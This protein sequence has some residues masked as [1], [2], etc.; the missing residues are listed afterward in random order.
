[1]PIFTPSNNFLS[2]ART[3]SGSV[4]DDAVN[5]RSSDGQVSENGGRDSRSS[6][7]PL[8][9][10]AAAV[11]ASTNDRWYGTPPTNNPH[12]TTGVSTQGSA[13]SLLNPPAAPAHTKQDFTLWFKDAKTEA[14]RKLKADCRGLYAS[15]TQ[16]APGIVETP[17]NQSKI[18]CTFTQEPNSRV[19]LPESVT[20]NGYP[21]TLHG[22]RQVYQT[23]VSKPQS[24]NPISDAKNNQSIIAQ[25]PDRTNE[26]LPIKGETGTD[27]AKLTPELQ[28]VLYSVLEQRKGL[29]QFVSRKSHRDGENQSEVPLLTQL[30]SKLKNGQ[31]RLNGQYAITEVNDVTYGKHKIPH[32]NGVGYRHVEIKI[33]DQE[34]LE[35]PIILRLSQVAPPFR[36]RLLQANELQTVHS[37]L[38]DQGMDL[39]QA[40]LF[41]Y[42]GVGRNA[43]LSVYDELVKAI[44]VGQIRSKEQLEQALKDLVQSGKQIRGAHFVQSPEQMSE[45]E[46]AACL[47]LNEKNN[48]QIQKIV[49]KI[50]NNLVTVPEKTPHESV[51]PTT[52][53]SDENSGLTPG[54]VRQRVSAIEQGLPSSAFTQLQGAL[55]ATTQNAMRGE[56]DKG[57]EA[58]D[59]WDSLS[60]SSDTL[61]SVDGEFN[62]DSKADG[63]QKHN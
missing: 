8:L 54:T 37:I 3:N 41:S 53:K 52:D 12:G 21:F 9:Q 11:D 49:E 29:V 4:L 51:N 40:I 15:V 23:I 58:D 48:E 60:F 33:T 31:I 26:G 17:V 36:N 20:G 5:E 38:R 42:A 1:M 44:D 47:Y 46:H 35:Q 61:G 56:Q 22:H 62:H 39:R 18:P 6:S 27:A 50:F 32:L 57:G 63:V 28:W 19:A 59:E 13:Q 14:L 30:Q 45:I 2:R 55:P 10:A 25:T 16:S 43:S 34:N 7:S 24:P